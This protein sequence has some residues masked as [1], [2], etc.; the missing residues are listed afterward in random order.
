MR[1]PVTENGQYLLVFGATMALRERAVVA[2]LRVFDGPL[3][4]IARSVDARAAKFFDHVLIGDFSDPD[5]ALRVV[6]DFEKETGLKPASTSSR[7][8]TPV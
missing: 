1:S 8:S 6:L 7:S 2:A 5:T 3:V 4:T